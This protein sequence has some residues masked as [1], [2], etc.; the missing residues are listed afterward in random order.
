MENLPTKAMADEF[1]A[2]KRA[3]LAGQPLGLTTPKT[4]IIAQAVDRYLTEAATWKA[5][6]TVEHFDR[7]ALTDLARRFGSVDLGRVTTPM[8]ESWKGDLSQKYGPHT[9]RMKLR[10]A[11]AFFNWAKITPNPC[12]DVRPPRTEPVGRVLSNEEIVLLLDAMDGVPRR[13][14]TFALYTG[15][16]LGELLGIQWSDI[17]PTGALIHAPKTNTLRVVPLHHRAM[18]ALGTRQDGR[19]AFQITVNS[20]QWAL[21]SARAKTGIGRVRWHDF[22]HTWATRMME[23]TNDFFAVQRLGGWRSVASMGIYQHLT[24]VKGG[25]ILSLNFG[26]NVPQI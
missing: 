13:A 24:E 3:D 16:R 23:Q 19:Q 15:V 21:R 5:K 10:S 14:A 6:N 7:P 20:L 17:G 26:A 4:E 9:V 25:A 8:I 11:R 1:A 18:E 2:R 12:R 22:R